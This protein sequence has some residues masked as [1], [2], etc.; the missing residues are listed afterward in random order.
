MTPDHYLD[1]Q[2]K[3]QEHT[4]VASITLIIVAAATAALG[5]HEADENITNLALMPALSALV[6]QAS[7]AAMKLIKKDK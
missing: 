7:N 6:L 2:D 4:N 5:I 3:Q 1:L